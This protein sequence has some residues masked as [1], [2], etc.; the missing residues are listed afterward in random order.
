MDEEEVEVGHDQ[1]E[2]GAYRHGPKEHHPAVS[3]DIE[4]EHGQGQDGEGGQV[5][6]EDILDDPSQPVFEFEPVFFEVKGEGGPRYQQ[7]AEAGEVAGCE[8]VRRTRFEYGHDQ[9][10][11]REK[12]QV[13]DVDV[14]FGDGH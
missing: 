3:R 14:P 8:V 1:F 13:E 11:D 12:D 5:G 9:E 2:E 4:G 6:V 7:Y 10:R